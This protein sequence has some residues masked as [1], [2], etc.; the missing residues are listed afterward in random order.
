MISLNYLG[1]TRLE[2]VANLIPQTLLHPPT[3][4]P[5]PLSPLEGRQ[6]P[7]ESEWVVVERPSGRVTSKVPIPCDSVASFYNDS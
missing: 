7:R 5:T 4:K 2:M 6:L 1:D 3:F